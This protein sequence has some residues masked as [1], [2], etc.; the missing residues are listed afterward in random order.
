[1]RTFA[2]SLYVFLLYTFDVCHASLYL[3]LTKHTSEQFPFLFDGT[4]RARLNE[5]FAAREV[6][7]GNI[8]V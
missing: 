1:M 6:I 2:D 7:M 5:A 8:K 4:K 3:F